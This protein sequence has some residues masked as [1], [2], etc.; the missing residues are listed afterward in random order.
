MR[1]RAL[2]TC[3]EAGCATHQVCMA[4][5]GGDAQCQPGCEPGYTWNTTTRQCDVLAGLNC[6][7]GDAMSLVAMCEAAG[8]RCVEAGGSAMCGGCV[9]GRVL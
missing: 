7:V 9:D 4:G 1:C 5:P 2:R 6:R 8:R 3:A